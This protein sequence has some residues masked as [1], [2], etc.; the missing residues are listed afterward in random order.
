MPSR[1]FLVALATTT[2]CCCTSSGSSGFGELQLILHLHLGDVRIGALSESQSDGGG[3]RRVAGG[4]DVLQVVEPLHLL[5]DRLGD[6]GCHRL[7]VRAGDRS[8]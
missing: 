4:G 7:G 6:G 3:A 5:L 2:P 8:R 1:K